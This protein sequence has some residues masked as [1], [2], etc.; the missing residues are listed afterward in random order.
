MDFL[1]IVG[2]VP[3]KGGV[4]IS[5]AKNSALPILAATLLSQQEVKIKSLPQ[6]VDIKAM[7]LLLQNLGASLEWLN[8][9]TLQI[10]TK[11][12]HHTEAT[13]DL[14][15][16]MRAS[17]LVLGPLLARF[18]ECL[19]SLPGGCAIGARPVDLHLKAMQQLGAEIKIEQGYIHAKAPKGLKGNDILF[20]KISVTGTE[21][22]LMAAS[23]AK[24]ITRIINAAKEPEIAQLCA[25]LQSGG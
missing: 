14:V 13:Y 17:I 6:V 3:L 22:A 11:S 18:K 15:R 4:E 19:V 1:E 5:G 10:G 9:N 21:N 8:P 16:K 20:D 12:L 25:F 2:Q 23:L 7:A 24:G